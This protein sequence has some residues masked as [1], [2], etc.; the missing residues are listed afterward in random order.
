MGDLT[1]FSEEECASLGR[2][3]R[4][5][6]CGE[7]TTSAT[8][9]DVAKWGALIRMYL[10]T[11]DGNNG[12]MRTLPYSGG[13]MAQ[14]SRTMQVF[15]AIQDAFWEKIARDNESLKVRGR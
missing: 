14:P 10:L 5:L 1:P 3:A 11:V 7:Q 2:A 13:L 4:T 12:S 6:I 15:E 9:E 8:K